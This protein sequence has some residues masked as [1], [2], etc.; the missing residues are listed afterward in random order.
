MPPKAVAPR[1]STSP[2]AAAPRRSSSPGVPGAARAQSPST[3]KQQPPPEQ[4]AAKIKELETARK[5]DQKAKVQQEKQRKK[6][7]ADAKKK[8]TA[9]MRAATKIV[10][11][12]EMEVNKLSTAIHKVDDSVGQAKVKKNKTLEQMDANSAK[13]ITKRQTFEEKLKSEVEKVGEARGKLAHI[14]FAAKMLEAGVIVNTEG[15]VDLDPESTGARGSNEMGEA[16]GMSPQTSANVA[17]DRVQEL[18][19][20][21]RQLRDLVLT[22]QDQ[23][24]RATVQL[25]RYERKAQGLPEE[26]VEGEEDAYEDEEVGENRQEADVGEERSQMVVEECVEYELDGMMVE[27]YSAK[28]V[29]SHIEQQPAADIANPFETLQDG[30]SMELSKSELHP[31]QPSG[32]ET[33][34]AATQMQLEQQQQELMEIGDAVDEHLE[35][36]MVAQQQQEVEEG[37]GHHTEKH[38]PQPQLVLQHPQQ[39]QQPQQQSPMQQPY[40]Q[41]GLPHANPAQHPHQ[42][43]QVTVTVPGHPTQMLQGPGHNH[44]VMTQNPHLQQFLADQQGVARRA[45]FGKVAVVSGQAPLVKT[46]EQ[47][48]AVPQAAA[49][50]PRPQ[51]QRIPPGPLGCA[52]VAGSVTSLNIP[53]QVQ[54]TPSP[55]SSGGS[56]VGGWPRMVSPSASP[57]AI[58]QSRN[59]SAV[60]P[61]S[62]TPQGA[63]QLQSPSSADG[64]KN[65]HTSPVASPVAFS[66]ADAAAGQRRFMPLPGRQVRSGSPSVGFTPTEPVQ[67]RTPM[68]PVATPY[69]TMVQGTNIRSTPTLL[70]AVRELQGPN[71]KGPGDEDVASSDV[72]SAGI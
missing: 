61:H 62:T 9:E 5:E 28:N 58:A 7:L 63:W 55:V 20:E 49:G 69:A 41:F 14:Q 15:T 26:D 36:L 54:A 50:S 46:T 31:I 70:A 59:R 44:V 12:S 47:N 37:Q 11:R 16:T 72:L 4:L 45:S 56:A 43:H 35:E 51:Q 32:E 13:M 24:A 64:S 71:P 68:E 2:S 40:P 39:Q 8:I 66:P 34:M 65:R 19:E 38:Q 17:E 30:P 67:Q 48:G 29:S 18:E 1:T 27:G 21:N 22:L 57:T 23:L 52:L 42:V 60:L 10:K 3:Q 33:L 6:E 53:G 25:K